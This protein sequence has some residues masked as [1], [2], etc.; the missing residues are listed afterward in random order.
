MYLG[1]KCRTHGLHFMGL[2]KTAHKEF[3][4]AYLKMKAINYSPDAVILC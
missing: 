3:P 4:M 2:V 1:L